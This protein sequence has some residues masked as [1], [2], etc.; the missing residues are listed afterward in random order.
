[1]FLNSYRS[2]VK[3]VVI[4][5]S[6]CLNSV[7]FEQISLESAGI[8]RDDT[9]K[10]SLLASLKLALRFCFKLVV[11]NNFELARFF[12]RSKRWCVDLLFL[13]CSIRPRERSAISFC[14]GVGY[15]L[16]KWRFEKDGLSNLREK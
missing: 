10:R 12:A 2:R 5:G 3:A 8:S 6:V 14:Q 7:Y 13:S 15:V 11:W 1:M 16:V 4:I 9:R